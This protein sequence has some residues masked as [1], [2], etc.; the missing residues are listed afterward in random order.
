MNEEEKKEYE[1]VK[2]NVFYL[3]W[4]IY[5]YLLG[6]NEIIDPEVKAKIM[7]FKHIYLNNINKEK[8]VFPYSYAHFLDIMQG[9]QSFVED[10]IYILNEI[11]KNWIIYEDQNNKEQ[12]LL[13]KVESIKNEYERY[14]NDQIQ[15]KKISSEMNP[16][17]QS[18]IEPGWIDAFN[19]INEIPDSEVKT[20]CLKLLNSIKKQNGMKPEIE[21]LKFNKFI[22]NQKLEYEGKK[23]KFPGVNE[24]II[25]FEMERLKK[26]V[27]SCLK[28]SDYPFNSSD[29]YFESSIK[30][31]LFS[32]FFQ[33]VGELC[34]LVDLIG[35]T[36]EKIKGDKSFQGIINDQIHLSH[37]L[38]SHYFITEDKNLLVK[39]KFIKKWLNLPVKIF[40]IDELNKFLLKQISI[41]TKS[42]KEKQITYT[43]KDNENVEIKRYIIELD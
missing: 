43:F 19:T 10:K 34:G 25:D 33:K 8:T 18:I 22:R 20:A 2:N 5:S 3:D 41:N 24:K 15:G 17:I 4:N 9:E 21:T 30:V 1:Q 38:R 39:S 27:D 35:L 42:I 6:I 13:N 31:P 12:V 32:N 7:C 26:S 23:F 16:F 28:Q 29:D 36:S 40:D 11:S 14:L 37:G